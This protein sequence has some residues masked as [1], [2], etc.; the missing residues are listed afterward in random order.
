[1]VVVKILVEEVKRQVELD[2]SYR[3]I[4][5]STGVSRATIGNIVNSKGCYAP[6]GSYNRMVEPDGLG[7]RKAFPIDP[8]KVARCPGCGAM[9][10]MP[11]RACT[12]TRIYTL[13]K[14]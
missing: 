10:E 12:L 13:G 6:G 3:K 5:K 11:C 14:F 7:D 4:A 8:S 9:V 1:M 2:I